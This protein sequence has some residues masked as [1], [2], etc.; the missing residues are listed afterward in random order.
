MSLGDPFQNIQ[1]KPVIKKKPRYHFRMQSLQERL[2]HVFPWPIRLPYGGWWLGRDDVCSRGISRRNFEEGEWR[3]V[4]RFLKPDM[5]VLDVGAHHGFYTILCSKKVGTT[6]RVIAFEPSPGE[7]RKLSFHLKL[8]HCK[9]VKIEPYALAAQNGKATLFIIKGR[10][11]VFN[12]LRPPAVSMP[13]ETIA[14]STIRLDDYL[15]SVC[16]HKVDFVKIDAEGAELEIL[17]GAE[18]SLMA[19]SSPIMMIEVSD[20]RTRPWGYSSSAIYDFLAE[21]GYTWFSVTDNGFLRL[22]E[23][24]TGLYNFVAVPKSKLHEMRAYLEETL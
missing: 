20:D 8:N 19:E 7:Q 18:H 6:G 16:L 1:R 11:T 4:E 10:D 13:T 12:S 21:Q 24:G 5:I 3:F 22:Y 15:K 23:K 17:Q 9:N 14:V 2:H